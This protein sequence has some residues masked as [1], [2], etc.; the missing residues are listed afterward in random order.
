MSTCRGNPT[1][2]FIEV[3]NAILTMNLFTHDYLYP[4]VLMKKSV[5]TVYMCSTVRQRLSNWPGFGFTEWHGSG[6]GLRKKLHSN[7]HPM[8]L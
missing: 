3:P 5:K 7:P 6:R 8:Q 2:S 4:A 1:F